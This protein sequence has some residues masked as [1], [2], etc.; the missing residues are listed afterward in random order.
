MTTL[1]GQISG[2]PDT[3]YEGGIFD[4][5]I[6]ELKHFPAQSGH[7]NEYVFNYVQTFRLAIRLTHQKY[8]LKHASGIQTLAPLL[9]QSVSMFWGRNGRRR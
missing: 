2:P 9:A 7:S 6:G 5:A 4:L 1:V 8:D 3:A